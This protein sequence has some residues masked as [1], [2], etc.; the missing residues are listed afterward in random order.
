MSRGLPVN[1]KDWNLLSIRGGRGK[2]ADRSE[3]VGLSCCLRRKMSY[4][5]WRGGVKLARQL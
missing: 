4:A 5:L 1:E 2:E 3:L